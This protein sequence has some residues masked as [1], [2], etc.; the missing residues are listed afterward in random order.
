MIRFLAW[1]VAA[2][3]ATARQ[4]APAQTPDA[5]PSVAI[6]FDDLPM[7][8]AGDVP[9]A[10]ARTANRA[11]VRTLRRERVPARAAAR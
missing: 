4:A 11:I 8:G 1:L 3:L 7:A 5:R 6:T 2:L 10:D 9:V